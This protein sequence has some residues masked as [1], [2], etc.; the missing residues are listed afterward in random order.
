MKIRT[1]Q[2]KQIIKEEVRRVREMPRVQE[3]LTLDAAQALDAALEKIQAVAEKVRSYPA[4][5]EYADSGEELEAVLLQVVADL[6]PVHASL[7]AGDAMAEADEGGP[8]VHDI[9]NLPEPEAVEP[10]GN[11]KEDAFRQIV[12]SSSMGK[13]D[14][15]KVDLFSASAVVNVLD[16]LSPENKENFLGLPPAKMVQIAFKLMK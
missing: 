10:S 7:Q 12:A 1:A 8:G 11:P 13:V 14:G 2:L 9:M 15:Q 4:P 16:A 6:T 3:D 5:S